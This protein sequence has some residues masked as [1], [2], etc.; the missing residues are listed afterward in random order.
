MGRKARRAASKQSSLDAIGAWRLVVISEAGLPFK[1]TPPRLPSRRPRLSSAD[2]ALRRNSRVPK[3]LPHRFF[4]HAA[5]ALWVDGKLQLQIDP[6]QAIRR[7]LTDAGPAVFAAPLN[8]RR[9]TIDE[10]YEWIDGRFCSHGE[11][12]VHLSTCEK[13]R[14]Q[15]ESYRQAESGRVVQG[16]S[17]PWQKYT[18]CMEGALY[19]VEL[20]SPIAQCL[21]CSWFGAVSYTHL[22]LPTTPYV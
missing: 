18:R 20:R 4:P 12:R 7:F 9:D 5:Y 21:L 16:E 2:E 3:L 11:E 17:T 19:L 10:E 22:T 6:L 15:Y 1:A 13:V 14:S 8:L